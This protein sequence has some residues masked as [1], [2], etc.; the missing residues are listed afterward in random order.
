MQKKKTDFQLW[1]FRY[2]CKMIQAMKSSENSLMPSML[3]CPN[4]SF[5]DVLQDRPDWLNISSV[6]HHCRCHFFGGFG[7][8]TG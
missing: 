3:L 7:H 6:T 4:V 1:S 8:K 5:S 2:I